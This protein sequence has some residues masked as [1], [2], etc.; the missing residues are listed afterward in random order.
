[1]RHWFETAPKAVAKLSR[2]FGSASQE[3]FIAGKKDYQLVLLT[4]GKTSENYGFGALDGHKTLIN[5][6]NI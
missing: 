1:M 5:K 3:P 4:H 2:S 6:G